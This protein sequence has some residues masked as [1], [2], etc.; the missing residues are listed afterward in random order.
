MQSEDEKTW[1]KSWDNLV[2]VGNKVVDDINAA[3][4]PD[5]EF[6]KQLIKDLKFSTRTEGALTRFMNGEISIHQCQ[7]V[8]AREND[9]WFN[10][11]RLA[12]EYRFL[13]ECVVVFWRRWACPCW[14]DRK[15]DL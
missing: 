7:V 3:F 2:R 10:P 11:H 13:K 1:Q 15:K 12:A 4:G 6:Q 5:S 8:M 9:W 14:W